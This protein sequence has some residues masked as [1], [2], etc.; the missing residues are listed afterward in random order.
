LGKGSAKESA[1]EDGCKYIEHGCNSN[2]KCRTMAAVDIT[3][4][5]GGASL[6]R[7]PEKLVD[8]LSTSYLPRLIMKRRFSAPVSAA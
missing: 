7:R 2:K 3:L 1:S 4:N 8:K 6:P 5:C